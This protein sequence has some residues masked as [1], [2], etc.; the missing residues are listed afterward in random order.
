MFEACARRGACVPGLV[1][2]YSPGSPRVGA[3]L[4]IVFQKLNE[5][6]LLSETHCLRA[7]PALLDRL[8]ELLY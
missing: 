8:F 5:L 6:L 7:E 3:A 2:I 1:L 4:L